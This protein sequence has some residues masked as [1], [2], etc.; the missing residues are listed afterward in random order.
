MCKMH[1]PNIAIYQISTLTNLYQRRLPTSLGCG[2]TRGSGVTTIVTS[3]QSLVDLSL[4]F[5]YRPN[6]PLVCIFRFWLLVTNLYVNEVMIFEI[7]HGKT[8]ETFPLLV[9]LVF[10]VLWETVQK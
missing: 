8:V 10:H 2:F 7:L 4:S 9:V 5:Q 1:V 3:K 6:F